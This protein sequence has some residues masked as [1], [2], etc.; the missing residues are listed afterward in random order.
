MTV[1]AAAPAKGAGASLPTATPASI[2][3]DLTSALR[4]T[5]AA[6]DVRELL[7]AGSVR[8]AVTAPTSGT[9]TVTLAERGSGARSASTRVLATA[10]VVTPASANAC[11]RS[12]TSAAG[13][14]SEMARTSSS[15]TAAMASSRRPAR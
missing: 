10:R 8:A 5:L 13:P 4:E 2:V 14:M 6:M 7:S 9:L 3:R 1:P 11:T 12:A 15:G